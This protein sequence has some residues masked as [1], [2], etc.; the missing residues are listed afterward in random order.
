MTRGGWQPALGEPGEVVTALV[1]NPLEN[2]LARGKTRPVVLVRRDGCRWFVMGLTTLPAYGSGAPRTQVPHPDVVG[3]RGP[4]FLW[5]ERLT[6]IS[7]IDIDR[8]IGWVDADLAATVI[9][10]AKLGA[11]EAAGLIRGVGQS[12]SAA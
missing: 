2:P 6:S 7:V 5:G 3:L 9:V 1:A 8:H 12:S 10:Q 4:G 11:R